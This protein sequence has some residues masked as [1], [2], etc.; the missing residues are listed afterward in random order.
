MSD[1]PY[2]RE[3][4]REGDSARARLLRTKDETL[5]FT[6][7]DL[8]KALDGNL[9]REVYDKEVMP[10]FLKYMDVAK[11]LEKDENN[12]SLF[13]EGAELLKKLQDKAIELE[14]SK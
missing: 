10:L 14:I 6:M 8:Y 9:S 7:D 3:E 4:A 5:K 1:K 11:K 13:N 2:D 12:E